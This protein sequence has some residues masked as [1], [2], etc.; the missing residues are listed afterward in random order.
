MWLLNFKD[1]P[2]DLAT[3]KI[4]VLRQEHKFLN[5]LFTT[6][7]KRFFFNAAGFLDLSVDCDEFVFSISR[8]ADWNLLKRL[9]SMQACSTYAYLKKFLRKLEKHLRRGLLCESCGITDHSLHKVIFNNDALL[10]I[11]RRCWMQ[12]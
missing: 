5:F 3:S 8:E 6:V 2:R 9:L 7:A 12:H 10:E 1:G 11:C 4:S